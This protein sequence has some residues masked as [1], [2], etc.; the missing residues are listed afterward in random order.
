MKIHIK[1]APRNQPVAHFSSF[2]PSSETINKKNLRE[3]SMTGNQQLDI[4]LIVQIKADIFI[5]VHGLFIYSLSPLL[6][7]F[8]CPRGRWSNIR[9]T[10]KRVDCTI[11]TQ[12]V[13]T[14]N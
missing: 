10:E 1:A 3:K 13:S 12:G 5:Q 6:G 2:T 8:L 9:T 4:N 14:E 7:S 11:H